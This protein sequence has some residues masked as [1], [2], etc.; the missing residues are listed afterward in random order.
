MITG[1]GTEQDPYVVHT[2]E[3]LKEACYYESDVDYYVKLNNDLDFKE[4]VNFEWETVE[5][6]YSPLPYCKV[7]VDLNNKTIKNF[8]VKSNNVMFK[9]IK[10]IKN[11]AILNV[12]GLNATSAFDNIDIE[13]LSISINTTG[14]SSYIFNSGT[15]NMCSICVKGVLLHDL[16]Y[17]YNLINSCVLPYLTSSNLARFWKA[18]NNNNIIKGSK[19]GYDE[20][21]Y[22]RGYFNTKNIAFY[23]YGDSI[24]SSVFDIDTS[25]SGVIFDSLIQ[26]TALNAI[27]TD[28]FT[29][30]QKQ[31][32]P[33]NQSYTYNSI[34]DYNT[35]VGNGF[36]VTE[37]VPNV[38]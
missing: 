37:V 32:V 34:R 17:G 36:M 13:N 25:V 19:I 38:R 1:T 8:I 35:L 18:I 22:P 26:N 33:T 10:T 24:L 23:M 11:G 28:G 30:T 14:F 7:I 6:I 3:E 9:N 21:V 15:S 29:E 4:D 2:Y 16:F 12:Y 27:N 20:N 5:G 31:N